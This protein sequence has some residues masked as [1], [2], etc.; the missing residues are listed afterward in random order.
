M[1]FKG[2][3]LRVKTP[4]TTNGISPLT[5]GGAIKYRE[6]HLPLSAKKALEAKNA[7]RQPHLKMIIEEVNDAVRPIIPVKPSPV[8]TPVE[9]GEA[10]T[11]A[12]PLKVEK[13]KG[14]RPKKAK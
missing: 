5:D 11:G 6:D 14:G 4:I 1:P 9:T 2:P 3:Y 12:E 8:E 13:K 10:D 7:K